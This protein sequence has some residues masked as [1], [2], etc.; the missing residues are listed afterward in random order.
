MHDPERRLLIRWELHAI[1]PTMIQIA[2]Y[3]PPAPSSLWRLA[4]RP[5][6][7][8]AA[9]GLPIGRLYAIGYARGL[10]QGVYS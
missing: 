4:K 2:E 6:V 1:I 10:R 9:G 7:D 8:D 5:G 3:L